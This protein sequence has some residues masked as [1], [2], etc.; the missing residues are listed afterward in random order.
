MQVTKR[1]QNTLSVKI[2]GTEKICTYMVRCENSDPVATTQTQTQKNETGKKLTFFRTEILDNL[3]ACVRPN[4]HQSIYLSVCLTLSLSVSLCSLSLT[5]R[6]EGPT[7]ICFMAVNGLNGSIN[8]HFKEK[9]INVSQ[10]QLHA[11]II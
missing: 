10:S 1:L 3:K 5:L 8:F 4:F 11:T 9:K 7:G 2:K 6:A